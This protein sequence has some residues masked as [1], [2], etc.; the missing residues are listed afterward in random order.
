MSRIVMK[1]WFCSLCLLFCFAFAAEAG[2]DEEENTATEGRS[3]WLAVFDFADLRL[4]EAA[5]G[6]SWDDTL[7][8][9]RKKMKNGYTLQNVS[10]FFESD[11]GKK[12][13]SEWEVSL[14]SGRKV[15]RGDA[16][17]WSKG[18]REFYVFSDKALSECLV[19]QFYQGRLAKIFHRTAEET[20]FSIEPV[21]DLV[22]VLVPPRQKYE[23]QYSF[24]DF[25]TV[26]KRRRFQSL[27]DD[28]RFLPDILRL[29]ERRRLKRERGENVE[30][31]SRII[32]G[33][34]LLNSIYGV[35]WGDPPQLVLKRSALTRAWS[36]VSPREIS[37]ESLSNS[38]KGAI[39]S[40]QVEPNATEAGQATYY[41]LR[42][43]DFSKRASYAYI[44]LEFENDRLQRID[45]LSYDHLLT[46]LPPPQI[47][48]R[49]MPYGWAKIIAAL[50][51]FF[52]LFLLLI[53]SIRR[54]RRNERERRLID[55]AR[56]RHGETSL[57]RRSS[58]S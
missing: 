17:G 43:E 53:S 12:F 24:P 21:I 35:K 29:A 6:V 23:F 47:E 13:L 45:M 19:L 26:K 52:I 28:Y 37:N 58:T 7:E 55:E 3:E 50:L 30:R 42:T 2:E 20:R 18:L 40:P 16:E 39:S 49:E 11:P 38:L 57:A 1:L 36:S 56:R 48:E 33:S 34:F 9:A 54:R 31:T 5:Y 41:F 14:Q 15:Q 22:D 32:I 4:S 46:A 10:T 8:S 44:V 27:G 25:G 51:A